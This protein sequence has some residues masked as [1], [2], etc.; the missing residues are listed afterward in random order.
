MMAR[1]V[2]AEWLKLTGRT[3]MMLLLV[4]NTV[5]PPMLAA[6]FIAYQNGYSSFEGEL[7]RPGIA[8]P[9]A[10]MR[11]IFGTSGLGCAILGT[12]SI[13]SEYGTQ[14]VMR[15]YQT[16][17][18]RMVPLVSK[19][20][21]VVAAVAFQALV[22][23]SVALLIVRAFGSEG[24]SQTVS[25]QLAAS[26]VLQSVIDAAFGYACGLFLSSSLWAIVTAISLMVVAPDILVLLSNAT[27][28]GQWASLS[29][30]LPSEAASVGFRSLLEG[31][32]FT[33]PSPLWTMLLGV[34]EVG[35]MI[36]IGIGWQSRRDVG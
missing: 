14:Q 12:L 7:L 2:R 31:A 35:V 13:T 9:S 8:S 16:F 28:T 15:T 29:W 27:G 32:A 19:L 25:P 22:A 17:Q 18:R 30:V 11:I 5:L 23:A 21:V 26:F 1:S 36:G 34:V 24:L 3:T 4:T 20:F 6:A 10:V 33:G